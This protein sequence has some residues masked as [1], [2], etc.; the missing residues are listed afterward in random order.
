MSS[1]PVLAFSPHTDDAEIGCGGLIQRFLKQ[2]RSVIIFIYS[3]SIDGPAE[4]E[5]SEC[6]QSLKILGVEGQHLGYRDMT[7]WQHRDRILDHMIWLKNTIN[8]GLIL[9]PATY[10]CHQDH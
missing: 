8:P 5:M 4:W 10:D 9:V 3:T 7:L 1:S 6:W 2:K